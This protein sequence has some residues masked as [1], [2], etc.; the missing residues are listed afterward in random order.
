MHS[1]NI[2]KVWNEPLQVMVGRS[3]PPAERADPDELERFPAIVPEK[4]SETRR[5]IESSLMEAGMTLRTRIETN[6]L[7]T[8]RM[9]V[10]SG[11]GWSVLPMIMHNE[12]LV[13]ISTPTII[14]ERE[15]SIVTRAGG[16]L[17]RAA[18]AFTGLLLRES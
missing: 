1:N 7:E 6:Y 18:Q 15:L 16:L 11:L 13:Y 14:F 9:F 5:L 3:H 8:I 4:G 2:K 12:D 10:A 17:S